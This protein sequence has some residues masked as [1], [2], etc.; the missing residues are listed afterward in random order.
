MNRVVYYILRLLGLATLSRWLK[1]NTLTLVLYH[2]VAPHKTQGLYNYRRMFIAPDAFD[3]QL[4]YLKKHYTVLPLEEAFERLH[5]HTLPPHAL[6]ITFDDGYRNNFTHAYPILKKHGL[7]ATFFLAT[8]FV[9]NKEPVWLD[10]LKY[11]IGSLPLPFDTRVQ[12]YG[13]A[14]AKLKKL[15]ESGKYERLKAIESGAGVRFADFADDRAVYAPLEKSDI[16][17][18]RAGGM[19]FGAHTESHP[20][21]SKVPPDQLKR[22]IV[23]SKEIV[24]RECGGASALFC[25]TNGQAEDFNDAVVDVVRDAGFGGAV[26]T[27]EGTNDADSDPYKLRRITMDGI[28]DAA[29]FA[30]AVSGLRGFLRGIFGV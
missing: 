21:L 6:A 1:R 18:M 9:F 8:N 23:N 29:T 25:Y 20:I 28:E 7:T 2:G 11:A 30:V 17:E 26:T 4:G 14:R 16:E 12:R 15:P 22:E 10:R 27:L 3:E 5:A 24:A 19:T 13:I